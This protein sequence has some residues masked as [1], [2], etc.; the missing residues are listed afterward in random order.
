[1]SDDLKT[2][3]TEIS[4]LQQEASAVERA[5]KSFD[6]VWPAVEAGLAEAEATFRR[7]G[8]QLAGGFVS[9]LPEHVHQRRQAMVGMAMVANR[10]GLLY[11]ERARIQAQTEGGLSATDKQRRLD[12][13]RAAILKA[14]ARRE[15]AL[16][17]VEGVGEFRPRDVHPE[18]VIY[19]ATEV[20]GLAR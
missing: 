13:L 18:L 19:P 9:E 7:L 1:M 4:R 6:E 11:S 12:Q 10:K 3:D 5:P 8:P 14:A 2:L 16:R 17:K 15:L 20:E